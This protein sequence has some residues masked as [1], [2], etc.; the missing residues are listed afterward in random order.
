M[1]YVEIPWGYGGMD[2]VALDEWGPHGARDRR[3]WPGPYKDVADE[4]KAAFTGLINSRAGVVLEGAARLGTVE[5]TGEDAWD[6]LQTIELNL[7][8]Q[9][10]R[11]VFLKSHLG[12]DPTIGV[13]AMKSRHV[14]QTDGVEASAALLKLNK[15]SVTNEQ[16]RAVLQ[17]RNTFS[18]QVSGAA[19]NTA[20]DQDEDWAKLEAVVVQGLLAHVWDSVNRAQKF[21]PLN[22]KSMAAPEKE[23]RSEWQQRQKLLADLQA[24][25]SGVETKLRSAEKRVSATSRAL[26]DQLQRAENEINDVFRSL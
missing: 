17:Q 21:M 12:A 8:D 25:K 15:C 20:W 11:D 2:Q 22:L 9:A 3:V 10:A 13:I 14:D 24:L 23:Y 7:R 6:K 16:A 26:A 1:L 19:A 4:K 5:I 18:S